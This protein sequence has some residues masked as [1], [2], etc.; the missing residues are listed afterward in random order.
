MRGLLAESLR[1]DTRIRSDCQSGDWNT[2][3]NSGAM[4]YWN[5]GQR[6]RKT[7]DPVFPLFLPQYCIIPTFHHSNSP[8]YNAQGHRSSLETQEAFLLNGVD[9]Q[10]N[11]YYKNLGT[12]R[13]PKG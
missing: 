12:H 8:K 10:F 7:I 6:G 9:S 13:T 1:K 5:D 11:F 3:W 2:R 4:E